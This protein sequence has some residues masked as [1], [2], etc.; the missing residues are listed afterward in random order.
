MKNHCPDQQEKNTGQHFALFQRDIFA[1]CIMLPNGFWLYLLQFQRF[2]I[3][4]PRIMRRIYVRE[5]GEKIN[6]T[7]CK[8]IFSLGKA[9]C[10]FAMLIAVSSV[11]STCAFVAYQPT[12]PKSLLKKN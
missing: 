1:E 4:F 7:I 11:N 12:A 10:A 5:R 2:N 9:A 8:V 6:K 3:S